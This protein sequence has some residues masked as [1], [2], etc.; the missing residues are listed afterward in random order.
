MKIREYQDAAE[1]FEAI[2]LGLGYKPTLIGSVARSYS[3]RLKHEPKDM[4]FVLP[5]AGA[6]ALKLYADLWEYRRKETLVERN[7]VVWGDEIDKSAPNFIRINY[8]FGDGRVEVIGHEYQPIF[9]GI[10]VDLFRAMPNVR[11]V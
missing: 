7:Y 10:H 6:K 11:D 2:L 5:N 1:K 3:Q 4:D 8:E 9:N